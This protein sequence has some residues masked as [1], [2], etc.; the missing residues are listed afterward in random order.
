MMFVGKWVYVKTRE[1][2]KLISKQSYS[3]GDF[4]IASDSLT[5]DSSLEFY[6][7]AN[8]QRGGGTLDLSD[9]DD[10]MGV[11]IETKTIPGAS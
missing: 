2:A 11:K 9:G 10:R 4:F 8:P 6:I 7:M 1:K 5:L 3:H